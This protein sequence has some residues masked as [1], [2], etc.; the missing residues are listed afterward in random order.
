MAMQ[1]ATIGRVVVC[2]V[3]HLLAPR[4]QRDEALELATRTS[5]C[6]ARDAG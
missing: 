4:Q 3:A 6:A 1:E 5:S 2:A